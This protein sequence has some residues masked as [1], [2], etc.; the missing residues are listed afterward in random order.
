VQVDEVVGRGGE[1]TERAVRPARSR[2]YAFDETVQTR[3]MQ[4]GKP[5]RIERQNLGW[6]GLPVGDRET[7]L[8]KSAT[9][10]LHDRFRTARRT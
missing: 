8:R 1:T 6:E 7:G 4:L 9:Q 5:S 10:L 3:V 2:S